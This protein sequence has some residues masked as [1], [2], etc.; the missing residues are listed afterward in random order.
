MSAP[1]RR[2]GATG[3]GGGARDVLGDA[4][5]VVVISPH[6]DDAVLSAYAVL[7]AGLPAT[8]VTVFAGVPAPGPAS[9]W[10]RASGFADAR[11]AALA[12][13]AE[14]VAALDAL[15]VA[16]V[17]LDLV[18]DGGASID[19]VRDTVVAVVPAGAAVVVPAGAGAAPGRVRRL[20]ARVR[21]RSAGTA[22]HAEHV[23]VRRAVL[24]ALAAPG[25]R[26]VA[27]YAEWPYHEAE[28]VRRLARR[29]AAECGRELVPAGVAVDRDGKLAAAARYRT[30]VEALV[31]TVDRL[32][33]QLPAREWYL[34][35][36]AGASV[37]PATDTTEGRR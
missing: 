24:G 27:L 35:V 25:D 4:G 32:G 2:T 19:A 28:P 36:Q 30:Q 33:G 12:R 21:R 15:G 31:G 13:R 17:H 9:P 8:V 16:H 10:D 23:L 18:G 7:T 11:D 14:D 29:V 22:P 6:L 1:P 20:G 37:A 26:T 3:T 5:E 34:T